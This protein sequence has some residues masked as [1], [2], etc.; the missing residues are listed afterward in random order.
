MD[1]A[2]SLAFPLLQWIISSNRSH[3]VK[4][5]ESKHI[6]SMHTDHQYLLLSAPPEKEEKFRKLREKHG[7][8]FAFH[9]SS[10]EN[11]H[12]ILRRGLLNASGTKLQM[13][14]AAYGSGIYLSPNAATSFGYSKMYNYTQTEIA[15]NITTKSKS[16]NRFLVQQN[17][18]C[19]ALCEVIEHNIKKNSSIWVQPDE[20]SVVTRF[21]FVYGATTSQTAYNCDTQSEE[22]KLE[23]H[24][25]LN[26][27]NNT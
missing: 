5:P 27:Y 2:H 19:I 16:G 14:G 26:Y 10:V 25:A 6:S 23:I 18:Y 4:I 7:S 24:K 12:S 8:T 13:N 9:G 3:I 22:F 17:V 15:T 20:D 21:F 11:W 1:E